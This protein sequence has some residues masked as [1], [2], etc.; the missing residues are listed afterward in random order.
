MFQIGTS[1]SEILPRLVAAFL[2]PLRELPA[3]GTVSLAMKVVSLIVASGVL[4]ACSAEQK[5]ATD[6]ASACPALAPAR[7]PFAHIVRRAAAV[8]PA[9][10]LAPEAD[11]LLRGQTP[12][13][14]AMA[15]KGGSG[16]RAIGEFEMRGPGNAIGRRNCDASR[17][18]SFSR[19]FGVLDFGCQSPTEAGLFTITLVPSRVGLDGSP[20][21]MPLRILKELPKT[22]APPDGWVAAPLAKG[23]PEDCE[24]LNFDD[25][26]V[27]IESNKVH[28][29]ATEDRKPLIPIPAALASRMSADHAAVVKYVFEDADGWLVLFDHGEFGGGAEWYAKSGGAPRSIDIGESASPTDSVPQNVNRAMTIDGVVYVLQGLTHLMTQPGQLAA[30]WREHDHFTSRVIARYRTEPFDW[31]LQND[32]TWLVATNEAIWQT[33]REGGVSLVTRLPDV[34]EYPSSLAKTADGTFYV[35]GRAGALRLTSV[36]AEHPRY[37]ADWLM[38]KAS[39]QQECWASWS[40]DPKKPRR[41]R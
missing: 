30:L 29:V 24:N 18:P 4:A 19:G 10:W 37:A 17:H 35:A 1:S 9:V 16:F 8:P 32:G 39:A 31:L 22:A 12:L 28:L 13:I 34:L 2:A 33:S 6:P 40:A 25:Y 5:V 21:Q 20:A 15:D 41:E 23:K 26:S 7:G 3:T 36:W 11:V 27:R 38:P 14:F